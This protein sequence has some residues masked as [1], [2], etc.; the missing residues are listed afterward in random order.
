MH[1][2]FHITSSPSGGDI[3]YYVHTSMLPYATEKV[4]PVSVHYSAK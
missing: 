3:M 1:A 2:A 4:I